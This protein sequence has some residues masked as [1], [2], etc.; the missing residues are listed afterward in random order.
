MLGVVSRLRRNEALFGFISIFI[1]SCFLANAQNVIFSD[2]FVKSTENWKV[3]SESPDSTIINTGD[4]ELE[5]I[6]PKGF[7]L[8]LN[9][10]LEADLK[11]SFD[12]L[13]IKGNGKYDR[14]SDLNCF[15]MANDPENP[16]DFFA[17][18]RWRNGTFGK[19]YSLKL[20]YV[21][22]GGNS[23]TTT[24]FRKYDGDYESFKNKTMRPDIIKEYDD[25]A[26]MI[27]PNQW[28]HVEIIMSQNNI[29]YLFNQE[30]LFDYND[31]APYK[32]GYF[33]FRTVTNHMKIKNFH[34]VKL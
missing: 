13:V 21:G 9:K 26:H 22:Y 3:E 1:S 5:I 29:K 23:N 11:I 15:W 28:N 8:W 24:R 6:A 10:P 14:V 33:G 7:T 32:K 30:I 19:Y 12:A 25:S 18:S 2:N 4:Q 27:H 31:L 34:V 17:R 16:G 20:Y